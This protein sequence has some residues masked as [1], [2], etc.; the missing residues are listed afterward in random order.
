LNEEQENSKSMSNLRGIDDARE[1]LSPP[2][3][4][5]TEESASANAQQTTSFP[6]CT[7]GGGGTT[8]QSN[9]KRRFFPTWRGKPLYHGNEEAL[10]WGLD[11]AAR[12]V[13]FVAMGAFVGTALLR[14]A[15]EA[16]GCETQPAPADDGTSSS[17]VP[18]CNGR[19]YGI[20]PSSLL[21]TY[22]MTVGVVSA[23]LMPLVRSESSYD[24]LV[25]FLYIYSLSPSH[26]K[27]SLFLIVYKM[28]A[29]VD[30]T[31]KRLLL[32]RISSVIFCCLLV[33]P[34]FIGSET[35]FAVAIC[36]LLL[37]FVGWVQT[38]VTYAYLPELTNSEQHLTQYTQSFSILSFAS[39]VLLL[40]IVI[41]IST[42]A[43]FAK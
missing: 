39:M 17:V 9:S 29:F 27:Y 20:R 6:L 32:G 38:M 18:E 15:K 23:A 35:W 4:K 19:V 40:V 26:Y 14:L 33:P 3:N 30:Y 21:T 16:A 42:L 10:A 11:I 28:G 43:G 31:D 7:G 34:I 5:T 2:S 37:A 22:T 13:A 25:F 8:P 12:G 36:L 24:A 1:G 41:G